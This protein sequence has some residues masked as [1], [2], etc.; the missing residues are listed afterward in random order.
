MW[1][2][3]F[4]NT[5][6]EET[7]LSPVWSIHPCWRSFN[8]VHHDFW[9]IYSVLLVSI[10]V[11]ISVP[12]SFAYCSFATCFEI[13]KSGHLQTYFLFARLFWFFGAPW[14]CTHNL[15]CLL[16]LEKKNAFGILIDIALSLYIILD[17]LAFKQY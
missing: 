16:F 12:P 2:S 17:D 3:S 6:C 9:V 10:S 8:Q 11:S 14:N 5:I 15:R 7:V 13:R 1:I 4:P